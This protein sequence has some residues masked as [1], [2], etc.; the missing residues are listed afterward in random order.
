MA[1][2]E[3]HFV[4]S[5]ALPGREADYLAWY[6]QQ[7]IYDT[8][9]VA[10]TVEGQFFGAVPGGVNLRW[11]H[12][13][14]YGFDEGG[15]AIHNADVVLRRGT[16]EMPRTDAIDREATTFLVAKPLGAWIPAPGAPADGEV[17]AAYRLLILANAIEG[18]EAEFNDF[19]DQRHIHD[20]L[21]MP[22]FVG[23]QRFSLADRDGAP[24]PW[25]FAALYALNAEDPASVFAEIARRSGTPE[26]PRIPAADRANQ[27]VGLFKAITPRLDAALAR[28]PRARAQ[29]P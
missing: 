24:T 23:G 2:A 12:L 19:Y 20:A 26:M 11:G 27:V 18:R 4:L 17:G 1:P 7:H 29:R 22:G 14:I 28:E 13:G 9:R 25:R 21:R 8:L 3:R 5:G 16:P 10:G 6:A 15:S